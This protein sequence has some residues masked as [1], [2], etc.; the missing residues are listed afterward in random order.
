MKIAILG[1]GNVGSALGKRL[2]EAGHD[3]IYGTRDPLQEKIKSLLKDTGFGAQALPL[4][5]AVGQSE[6]IILA[7]PWSSVEEI[8]RQNGPWTS[9]IIVDCTNPLKKDLSG[10]EFG[11]DESAAEKIAKWTPGAFV[12]K[13]FNTTGSKNMES[14]VIHGEKTAMFVCGDDKSAKQKVLQLAE[15]IGFE[16]VDAGNLFAARYLEAL[17]MLWIHL[18][19]K[20]GMGVDFAI[21]LL[22]R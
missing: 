14:P 8:I 15:E 18:A 6:V 17:A 1:T 4:A 11:Q 10:L 22:R 7:T 20:Q 19:L 13:A 3:L 5:E 12:I 9:K 2:A 16:A 21:K